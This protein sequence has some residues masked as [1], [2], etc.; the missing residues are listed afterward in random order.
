[1][2]SKNDTKSEIY[3]GAHIAGLY[4]ISKWITSDTLQK[5]HEYYSAALLFDI[6]NVIYQI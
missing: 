4:I 2:S 5:H 6:K 3:R 1:M